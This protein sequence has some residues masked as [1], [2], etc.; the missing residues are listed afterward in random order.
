L[1]KKREKRKTTGVHTGLSVSVGE[2]FGNP[3]IQETQSGKG[4]TQTWGDGVEKIKVPRGRGDLVVLVV[5]PR[6]S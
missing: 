6:P 3:T 5:Q 1:E 4:E 2:G